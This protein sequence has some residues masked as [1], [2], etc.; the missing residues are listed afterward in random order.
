MFVGYIFVTRELDAEII[1]AG[2]QMTYNLC[3]LPKQITTVNSKIV[4][5]TYFA[6]GT[7]FKAV[8]AAGNGLAYTGSLRWRV[9]NGTLTPE[10]MAITGGRA[11]CDSTNMW[12]ANY[13]I[14]DHLGSVRAV[15]D[16]EGEV[17]DT[18][19][20]MP[21]G[22]EISSTSSA[23]T[24]YRFT[25]K[26]KQLMF[27]N[28][29]IYDS[30]ARFQNTYGR[31]MSSDPKAERFYHISPYTYC[32]GD[33]VN[34]VDPDGMFNIKTGEIEKGDNLTSITKQI[35]DEYNLNLT[36]LDIA[37]ANG[38]DDINKITAGHYILLPGQNI[39]LHFDLK[40]LYV[41]DTTYSI[42]MPGLEWEGTSG[43]DGYQDA[44][45]QHLK[46]DGPIPE[47][48]WDV[49]YHRTQHFE[50]SNWLDRIAGIFMRGKWKGGKMS[51]GAH[52]T[53]IYPIGN[54]NT[55]GRSGFSIHGGTYPGSAGCIDLTTHNDSFHNWL[56][57]NK[58]I[59]LKVK[60][61]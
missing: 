5:Y 51:W 56:K 10:S 60:N 20:Y 8:D 61:D 48:L 15:T 19:D 42:K 32:A 18:F 27:G 30:F 59:I 21:Y 57:N 6:D 22:S 24:D 4:K 1:E 53:W 31:F 36:V 40:S 28:S 41:Y 58:H 33:P 14:T 38:I 13:Y 3:N 16:A 47:G 44:N 2:L 25:C 37:S 46:G 39:E 50:D 23:T 52:R 49:D 26:E 11:V 34:L 54:T 55:Y 35:N 9:E 12:S 45:F 7:K 29:N 43:R 17:L